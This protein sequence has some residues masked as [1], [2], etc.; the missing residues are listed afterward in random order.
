MKEVQ[1]FQDLGELSKVVRIEDDVGPSGVDTLV[2]DDGK[3]FADAANDFREVLDEYY[4][5]HIEKRTREDEKIVVERVVLQ[6]DE[7]PY[8]EYQIVSES[9]LA[10]KREGKVLS[11]RSEK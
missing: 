6:S 7:L 5:D 3:R 2:L 4:G 10:R 9:S 1:E 8:I 11:D